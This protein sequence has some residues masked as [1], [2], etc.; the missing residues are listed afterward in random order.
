[1]NFIYLFYRS[2]FVL[3]FKKLS[4]SLCLLAISSS[5]FAVP[6]L[7]KSQKNIEEYKLDNGLRVV[8]APNAKEDKVYMNVVYFTGALD[9][10]QGKGGLAHLLE[11]LMFKGTQEVQGEEFQRRL[12]QHTLMTNAMTSFH[13]TQYINVMR[14]EQK[15]VN[16]LLYLEAQR[17]AKNVI[18]MEHVPNEIEIVK[19]E[20][21][22][23]MDQ[24]F[25]VVRDQLFKE[26]YG[27]KSLGRAPIGDLDELQSIN[28]ND[29]QQFY[30]TWYKPNNAA[31][32]LAG[33][34][35]KQVTLQ[36]IEKQFAQIKPAV[37][38]PD[39]AINHIPP[40]DL[41][42]L[43]NRR[44]NVKKGSDYATFIGYMGAE[45]L[46]IQN[47]LGMADTVFTLE[48]S[49][50]LYQ[51]LVKTQQ[52]TNVGGGTDLDNQYNFVILGAGFTP[53]VHQAEKIEQ[54]L[55]QQIEHGQTLTD[56]EVNRVKKIIQNGLSKVE[57]DAVSFGSLLANYVVTTPHG[58]SKYFE[59][60]Q[61]LDKIK[62]HD[63][64]Q[65]YQQFFTPDKRL[66]IEIEPTPEHEKQAQQQKEA[67]PT[68][69]KS[70]TQ[71]K[72]EPLKDVSVYV[73]EQQDF[74]EESKQ[75][76]QRIETQLKQ[77]TFKN[78]MQY[79]FY[80]AELKDDKVYATLNVDLGTVQSLWGQQVHLSQLAYALVRGSKQYN[81]Q[82]VQDK[83]IEV[84]GSVSSSYTGSNRIK[85]NISAN[86]QYFYDYFAFMIDML[87]N[88]AFDSEDYQV[89]KASDLATLERSYTEPETVSGLT[90]SRL[91]D[92]YDVNDVRHELLPEQLKQ[93]LQASNLAQVK[94][95]YQNLFAMN[96][97]EITVTGEFNT[98]Q[99]QK[100]LQK[101]LAKW[102]KKQPYQRVIKPYQALTGQKVHALAEKR[103]FGSYQA[104]LAFPVGF[105]HEDAPALSVLSHILGGSQLS[106]RLAYEL[107]E[108]NNLTYGFSHDLSM[109]Y[110]V[111]SGY[112]SVAAHYQPG[113]ADKVSQAIHKTIRD[114]QEKEV[115]AQEV[116]AAKAE[117]L[118]RRASALADDKRV[119]SIL[120][121]QQDTE[122]TL[123][124]SIVRYEQIQKVSPADIQRVVKKYFDLNQ[125]VEVM[126]DQYGKPVQF[127]H[128]Q[129]Q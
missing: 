61:E 3:K 6:V 79:T 94:Q 63:I 119:H 110:F 106:S 23:R 88:P 21:E 44:F 74:L 40:L 89:N 53:Q 1:M 116:E 60:I 118:K 85:I 62:A 31:I 99:V 15:N 117:L 32:I 19:R 71:A 64:N 13:Y 105:K 20:R 113:L 43:K 47:Q 26:L 36:E 24:P 8:L 2:Y 101:T 92:F 75:S 11:H 111:D 65:T 59:D 29:L 128:T 122:R 9:D 27:N 54:T 87:Q 46:D 37:D 67:T 102:S 18:K 38:F 90:L 70:S 83:S 42:K 68:A 5:V 125:L 108:Q 91:T 86:K 98:Q 10:P 82:Q 49:G 4:L 73:A 95:L 103:E 25:S 51:Q 100:L 50:R 58:W 7:V 78:G 33:N 41:A 84:D 124:D 115:T 56:E 104:Y 121:A 114:L 69:L 77:G 52:A 22:I 55:I 16:E 93:Q 109:S 45:D 48:P 120:V 14:T 129:P 123:Q 30:T 12:D 35:D 57:S 126:A 80:P 81:L 39:R 97:A 34:F 28:L 66:I 107:R 76:S 72:P 112:W 96:H 127:A 17:M